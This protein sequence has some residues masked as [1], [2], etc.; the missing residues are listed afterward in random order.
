MKFFFTFLLLMGTSISLT[1][2]CNKYYFLQANKTI[3][4]EMT[5]NRGKQTGK[6]IYVVSNTNSSGSS[7]V[8]NQT[9]TDAKGKTISSATNKIK[10]SKGVMMMDIRSF[11]NTSSKQQQ[12]VEVK[13]EDVY[14]EYP[15]SMKT[16]SS[17][18]DGK[19]SF[20][21]VTGDMKGEMDLSIVNRKV[22]G[23][24]SVTTPAGTWDCYKITYTIEIK[25]KVA[26]ISIPMKF[27]ATEWF[28]PDFGV[29][30]TSGK[31]GDT[32]IISVK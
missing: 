31:F 26:G 14:I 21:T 28:A 13:G 24:E 12:T 32:Q 4:M 11:M 10:C 3:E 15:S 30:K 17:L 9:V 8:V 1:A 22:T 29:V 6:I 20:N 5:N 23:K 7:S 25:T 19:A 18:P 16:G 2:Q 27:D